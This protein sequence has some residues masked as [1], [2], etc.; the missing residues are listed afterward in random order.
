MLKEV[1]KEVLIEV[2]NAQ[3]PTSSKQ[4]AWG[5]HL[6]RPNAADAAGRVAVAAFVAAV[7]VGLELRVR[8]RD[9]PLRVRVG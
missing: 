7:A 5:R 3:T 4:T 9:L 8:G 1:L 6:V 2:S